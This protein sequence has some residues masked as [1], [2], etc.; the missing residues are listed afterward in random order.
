[1]LLAYSLVG[2]KG[3]ADSHGKAGL[4][5]GVLTAPTPEVGILYIKTCFPQH[6]L[7]GHA[8]R[9]HVHKPHF[10]QLHLYNWVMPT[11]AAQF[12]LLM[13]VQDAGLSHLCY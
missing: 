13:E 12:Q 9:W 10:A 1:M 5:S 3:N 8:S 6:E 2:S 7:L 4:Q 11:S